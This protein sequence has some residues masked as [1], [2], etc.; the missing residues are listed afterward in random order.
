V[1]IREEH[2]MSIKEARQELEAEGF[3]FERVI[4]VLPWQHILIFR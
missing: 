4:D 1:P 3:A 2:K